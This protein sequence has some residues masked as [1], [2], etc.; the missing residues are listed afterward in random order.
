MLR[1]DECPLLTCRVRYDTVKI[2]LDVINIFVVIVSGGGC[3][4]LD[5][6]FKPSEEEPEWPSL[7]MKRFV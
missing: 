7:L 5:D 4:Y 2:K 6:L 3:C 1:M